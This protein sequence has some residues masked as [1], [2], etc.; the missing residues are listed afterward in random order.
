MKFYFIIVK[1]QYQKNV[2]SFIELFFRFLTNKQ[3][4]LNK[5][6]IENSKHSVK[7]FF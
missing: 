7:Y 5:A 3:L 1:I 4:N 6:V 2:M